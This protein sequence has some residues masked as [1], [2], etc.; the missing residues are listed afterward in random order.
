MGW[1]IVPTRDGDT[2]LMDLLADIAVVGVNRP[3]L[4][5][6]S[7][8]IATLAY[9]VRGSDVDMTIV[10]G[11]VI[12]EDGKCSLVD[13]QSVM[14]EARARSRELLLRAGISAPLL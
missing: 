1:P 11:R 8:P 7:D 9:D 14:D 12:Y 2:K 10:N 13:E 3:H 5:P 6:L 4:Q